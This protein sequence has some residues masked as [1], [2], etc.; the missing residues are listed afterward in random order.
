MPAVA[1][2][3]P[4]VPEAEGEVCTLSDIRSLPGNL[5]SFIQK[6]F[7]S[8]RLKYSKTTQSEYYANIC[9]KCGMLS[10][11]FYL[12]SEPGGPFFPTSDEDAIHLT[13]VEIPLDGPVEVE[14]SLGMGVGDLILEHA[15]K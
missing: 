3:A 12:H 2:I 1:I 9:P 8:F 4:N 11:D 15:K 14:A 10:G 5:R 7:P 6:R 13:V